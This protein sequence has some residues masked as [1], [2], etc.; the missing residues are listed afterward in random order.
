MSISSNGYVCL[1]DNS[2]CGSSTRPTPNDILIGLHHN[3]DSTREGSGQI[4]YKRLDSKSLDF[5]SVKIYSNLF[6]PTLSL[7]KCS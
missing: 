5:E 7:I 2:K 4:Y 3:L 6:N 1:G